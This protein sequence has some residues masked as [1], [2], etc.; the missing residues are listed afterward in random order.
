MRHREKQR[1]A[2]RW[3]LSSYPLRRL[4]SLFYGMAACHKCLSQGV[5]IR[6]QRVCAC[7]A[8]LSQ[9]HKN[10]GRD[11]QIGVEAIQSGTALHKCFI[12]ISNHDTA[13]NIPRRARIDAPGAFHHIK[14]IFYRCLCGGRFLRPISTGFYPVSHRLSGNHHQVCDENESIP[15]SR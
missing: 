5:R 11:E 4:G 7:Q 8:N 14:H 15:T 9:K 12:Y 3:S 6:M 13:W 10:E 2:I 1:F